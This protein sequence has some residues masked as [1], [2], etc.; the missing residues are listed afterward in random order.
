MIGLDLDEIVMRLRELQCY[1]SELAA[2][3][4]NEAHLPSINTAAALAGRIEDAAKRCGSASNDK[5]MGDNMKELAT[6]LDMS[7]RYYLARLAAS[8]QAW[9]FGFS[10]TF[11]Y[12]QP[13]GRTYQ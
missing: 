7:Y 13:A 2:R 4:A 9:H 5:K 10:N 6:I 3:T 12:E 1:S 11:D 8:G